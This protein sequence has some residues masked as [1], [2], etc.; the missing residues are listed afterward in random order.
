MSL[1]HLLRNLLFLQA[2]LSQFTL[3]QSDTNAEMQSSHVKSFSG[4]S[5]PIG[6]SLFSLAWL[7]RFSVLWSWKLLESTFATIQMYPS[8]SGLFIAPG[9]PFGSHRFVYL[10]DLIFLPGISLQHRPPSASLQTQQKSP[11]LLGFQSL[12]YVCAIMAH[13]GF[14]KSTKHTGKLTSS[15]SHMTLHNSDSQ[16]SLTL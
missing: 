10:H 9:H 3:Y 6:Q 13:S 14:A 1:T 2:S 8:L 15:L 7:T 4:S 11:V 5:G 16:H 12:G